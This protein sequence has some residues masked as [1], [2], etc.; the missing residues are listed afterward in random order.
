MELQIIKQ[1]ICD[2]GR[3]FRH[4]QLCVAM[5]KELK[6]INRVVLLNAMQED[7]FEECVLTFGQQAVTDAPEAMQ[8]YLTPE[9]YQKLCQEYNAIKSK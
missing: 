6:G 9:T 4:Y 3:E 2:L 8:E 1:S 5:L 7:K